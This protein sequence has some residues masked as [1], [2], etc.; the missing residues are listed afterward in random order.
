M[1]VDGISKRVLHNYVRRGR[2]KGFANLMFLFHDLWH[3]VT[4][5]YC[6]L[7]TRHFL[8]FITS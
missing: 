7:R 6:D 2:R 4:D 5:V 1:I 3:Y 8:D